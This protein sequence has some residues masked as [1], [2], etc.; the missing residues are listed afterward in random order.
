MTFL[1]HLPVEARSLLHSPL[2]KETCEFLLQVCCE[3][4]C[5][6]VLKAC[7]TRNGRVSNLEVK[8]IFE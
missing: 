6:A 5:D 1:L 7:L 4:S 3:C 2:R 8:K